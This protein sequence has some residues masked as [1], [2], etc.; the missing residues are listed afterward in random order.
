MHTGAWSYGSLG[1]VFVL[2]QCQIQKSRIQEKG[3]QLT[4]LFA[5]RSGVTRPLTGLCLSL[6]LKA[7]HRASELCPKFTSMTFFDILTDVGDNSS[8]GRKKEIPQIFPLRNIFTLCLLINIALCKL[9][10]LHKYRVGQSRFTV[11][12]TQNRVYSSIIIYYRI[13][14][15]NN[16]KPTFA[17]P[18]ICD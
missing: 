4:V 15:T 17:P 9:E 14:P 7:S 18:C 3:T 6:S 11:V 2:S 10:V 13:F 16:C 12:S 1:K 8:I 5:R